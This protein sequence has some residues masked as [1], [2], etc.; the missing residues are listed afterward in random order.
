MEEKLT[1]EDKVK[2][3]DS[4][5]WKGEIYQIMK[6]VG[7]G[8]IDQDGRPGNRKMK[9]QLETFLKNKESYLTGKEK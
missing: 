6:G 9:G 7:K 1:H 3:Q 8:D 2:D 4:L 5:A